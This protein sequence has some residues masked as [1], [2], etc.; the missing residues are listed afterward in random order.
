MIDNVVVAYLQN[1]VWGLPKNTEGSDEV[2]HCCI[3]SEFWFKL[4]ASYFG[5]KHP[6]PFQ[7]TNSPESLI[8]SPESLTLLRNSAHINQ[9]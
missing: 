2:P 1:I 3:L 5:Q 9:I 7:H 8:P 4:D 6:P